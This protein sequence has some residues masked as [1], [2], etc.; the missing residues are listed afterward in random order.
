MNG[1]GVERV[2]VEVRGKCNAEEGQ[3]SSWYEVNG[4][5]SVTSEDKPMVVDE[6]T[7]RV[8]K[9]LNGVAWWNLP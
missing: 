7:G 2:V 1:C 3:A 5:R 8:L 6:D 9:D 4:F